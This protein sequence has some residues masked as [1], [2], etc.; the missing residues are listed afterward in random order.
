MPRQSFTALITTLYA[1]FDVVQLHQIWAQS[2]NPPR[3]YCDVSMSRNDLQHLQRSVIT[4]PLLQH[5]LQ[6]VLDCGVICTIFDPRQL[7]SARIIAFWCLYVISRCDL[8]LWP[9]DLESWW[10]IKRHMVKVCKSSNL[11]LNYG[12]ILHTLRHAVT[13]TFDLL[14]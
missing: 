14:T 11:R 5:V 13:M 8:D 7:I 4:H 10:C 3:S 2:S 6:F 12:Y 9:A 1:K